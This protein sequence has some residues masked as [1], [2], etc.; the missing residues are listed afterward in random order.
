MSN[1][2]LI[3]DGGSTVPMSRVRCSDEN[4]ELQKILEENPSLLPGEQINPDDP[5][6]WLTI[7]REMGVPDPAT[8]VD[9]WSIDFVVVD[10]SAI[11]TF[12]ECKRIADSRSR[13][14]VVGQMFEYAANGHHYWTK[15]ELQQCAQDTAEAAG[16]TIDSA[17]AELK[18]DDDLPVGQ[19]FQ[20]MEDNLREGQIRLVFFL[21]EGPPELRSIVDFVNKQMERSE[22]LLIEARQ[23]ESDGM[24]IVVPTLFGFTEQARA[25]KR[26]VTVA[27]SAGGS[28]WDEERFSAALSE[29]LPTVESDAI[30]R[31]Y[32][33]CRRAGF[34]ITWGAGK[35]NG[36][37]RVAKPEVTSKNLLVVY[38]NGSLCINF[39]N[40]EPTFAEKLKTAIESRTQLELPGDYAGKY[41]YVN[42]PKWTPKVDELLEALADL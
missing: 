30:M 36:S 24:R 4:E 14:E 5:R 37:Y 8:G 32:V 39:G 22:I 40:F 19:F 3:D 7:K 12:V 15:D 10:Q 20:R 29:G 27:T 41:E 38:T 35:V 18:P 34:S 17:L 6:R 42:S 23:Y 16:R 2:Y 13:R 26:R 1:A 25:V 11:P 31:F 21:E 28:R 9:R 33:E